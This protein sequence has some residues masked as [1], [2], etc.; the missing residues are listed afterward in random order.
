MD[1]NA[2]VALFVPATFDDQFTVIRDYA[3]DGT[4]LF[5]QVGQISDGVVIESVTAQS[6]DDPRIEA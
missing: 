1:D 2:P 6:R 5:E 3:G 4:L